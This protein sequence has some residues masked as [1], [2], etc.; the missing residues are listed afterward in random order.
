MKAD[1]IFT[2]TFAVLEKS[3]DLRS[4]KHNLTVSNVANMETPNYKPFD[5]IVRE[6]M[7]KAMGDA[8]QVGLTKTH[9]MH[10]PG[11]ISR[12]GISGSG[13]SGRPL[14][15]NNGP[16]KRVNIDQEMAGLAEN[17]LMYNASAQILA[18]KFQGLKNVIQEDGR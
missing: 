17:S 3:L 5:M 14:F 10:L 4:Q 1:A 15:G 8:H 13:F 2:K 9:A 12:S 18:M 16:G 6:E 11:R 7:A